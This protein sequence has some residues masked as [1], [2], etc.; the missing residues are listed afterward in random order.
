MIQILLPLQI[1]LW[2]KCLDTQLNKPRYYKSLGTSVIN[3]PLSPPSISLNACNRIYHDLVKPILKNQLKYLFVYKT[4]RI[5]FLPKISIKSN[6]I[7]SKYK[8][9]KNNIFAEVVFSFSFITISTESKFRVQDY[10]Q[11]KIR[12]RRAHF[13]RSKA[14]N[15]NLFGYF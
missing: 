10:I 11:E 7:F 4:F 9:C 6:T 5:L 3:I 12:A 1:T 13:S 8:T 14:P 2:H 15:F